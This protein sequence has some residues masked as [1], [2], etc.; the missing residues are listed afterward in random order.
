LSLD[1][2][3]KKIKASSKYYTRFLKLELQKAGAALGK[4]QRRSQIFIGSY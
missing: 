1:F 4:S 2:F 3:S